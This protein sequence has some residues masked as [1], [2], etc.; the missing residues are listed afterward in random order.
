MYSVFDEFLGR[1]T[2]SSRHPIDVKVFNQKLKLVVS[3]AKFIPEEMGE[4]FRDYCCNP[5]LDE[6]VE[7]YVSDAWAVKEF[8]Q[9]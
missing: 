7:K 9:S 3:D 8:L 4:Y 6:A 5:A 2:W 1:D